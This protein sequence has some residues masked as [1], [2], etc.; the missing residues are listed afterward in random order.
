MVVVFDVPLTPRSW[1]HG[2]RLIVSSARLERRIE[3]VTLGWQGLGPVVQRIVSLTVLLSKG[4]VKWFRQY[5]SKYT[6]MHVAKYQV[7]FLVFKMQ[8]IIFMKYLLF[9]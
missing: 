5:Y 2:P 7:L 6:N 1:R 3:P 8:A 9:I 4:F